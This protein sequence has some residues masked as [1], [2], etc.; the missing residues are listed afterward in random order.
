M[1]AD[2]LQ[3]GRGTEEE[4]AET[5]GCRSVPVL[6]PTSYCLLLS[7]HRL[8]GEDSPAWLRNANLRTV[9]GH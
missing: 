5:C 1:L 8:A 4:A 6:E 7:F 9:K 2:V 3:A